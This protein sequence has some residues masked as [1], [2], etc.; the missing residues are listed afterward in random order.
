MGKN[1]DLKKLVVGWGDGYLKRFSNIIEISEDG[2]S[3]TQIREGI[4]KSAN[5]EI[6]LIGNKAKYIKI[7]AIDEKIIIGSI[8]VYIDN[9]R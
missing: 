2:E 7:K 6:D 9:I 8:D 5:E 4:N 3:W 1:V